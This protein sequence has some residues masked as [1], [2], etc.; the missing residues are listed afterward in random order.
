MKK[1]CEWF[2]VAVNAFT[3]MWN[4]LQTQY[5]SVQQRISLPHTKLQINVTLLHP[6]QAKCDFTTAPCWKNS[7]TPVALLR[8]T[9]HYIRTRTHVLGVDKQGWLHQTRGRETTVI[10]KINHNQYINYPPIKQKWPCLCYVSTG[11]EENSRGW[12]QCSVC[13][14]DPLKGLKKY[15]LL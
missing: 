14:P 9:L 3:L 10:L 1:G 15:D 12:L 7:L 4:S 11:G 5:Y 13:S 2:C 6:S 8:F